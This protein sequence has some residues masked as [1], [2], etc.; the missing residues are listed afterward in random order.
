MQHLLSP[1]IDLL[2]NDYNWSGLFDT[3][4]DKTYFITGSE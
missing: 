1:I 2:R 3:L 4:R